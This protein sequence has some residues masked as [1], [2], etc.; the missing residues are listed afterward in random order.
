MIRKFLLAL[1]AILVPALYALLYF[2]PGSSIPLGQMGLFPQLVVVES[3]PEVEE[4]IAEEPQIVEAAVT[5]EEEQESTAVEPL[6]SAP[7]FPAITP[8]RDL[9]NM[10]LELAL[11]QAV[12]SNPNW[13]RLVA[14]GRMNLGLVDMSQAGNNRFASL[15]GQ[16]MIYAASLPKI[17]VLAAALDAIERGELEPTDEVRSDLRLMIARSN[18]Q[19]TTRT[20][21]RVGFENIERTMTDD[22]YR[23]YDPEFGGGLWVGKRYAAG[24]RRYPDPM[25]GISHAATAEQVCRFYYLLANNALISPEASMEMRQY[26]VDPELHHKFVNTLDQ[27][28]PRA[29]VYRKSGSWRNYHADSVWVEGPE[30]NYIFTALIDDPNGEQICRELMAVVDQMLQGGA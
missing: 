5:F 11:R 30:R 17:A 12:T 18:N 14:D 24:G 4:S 23:L 26:L 8:L 21:D 6:N 16:N 19:A 13:A 1:P 9:E 7:E 22:R 15:N 25:Q 3:E 28:A 27:V 29:S 2:L 20:I 10:D